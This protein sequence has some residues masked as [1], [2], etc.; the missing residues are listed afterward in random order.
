M[1]TSLLDKPSLETLD[2]RNFIPILLTHLGDKVVK[3]KVQCLVSDLRREMDRGSASL[4]TF[5]DLSVTYNSINNV[6]WITFL[7]WEW[8]VPFF[9][10]SLLDHK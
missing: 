5:L 8:K 3:E 2:L 4:L 7:V 10:G 6:F 1:V 9:A